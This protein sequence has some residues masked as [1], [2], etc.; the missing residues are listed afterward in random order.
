VA[1]GYPFET[2]GQDPDRL[3]EQAMAAIARAEATQL[4][5]E[6]AVRYGLPGLV[7]EGPMRDGSLHIVLAAHYVLPDGTAIALSFG[8]DVGALAGRLRYLAP[9]E[10]SVGL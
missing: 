8:H 5:H 6:M 1:F 9:A 2:V 3:S 4:L 10:R 7:T